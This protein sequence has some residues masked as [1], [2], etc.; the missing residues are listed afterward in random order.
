MKLKTIL[1]VAL[2]SIILQGSVALAEL[3]PLIPREVLFGNPDKATPKISPDGKRLAYL[4]P[5]EG[6][7]A[8]IRSELD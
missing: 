2:T 6:D 1:L 5:D 7:G 4:A 8:S 3:P